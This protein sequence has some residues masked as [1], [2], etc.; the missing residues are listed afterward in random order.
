MYISS[1]H[2]CILYVCTCG[3]EWCTGIQMLIFASSSF[4]FQNVYIVTEC[5][6]MCVQLVNKQSVHSDGVCHYISGCKLCCTG[7]HMEPKDWSM[8][9][10]S[11]MYSCIH[12]SSYEPI[13]CINYEKHT[14]QVSCFFPLS[15]DL[16]SK[17]LD[18]RT[19]NKWCVC[20][21]L[22]DDLRNG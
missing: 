12:M 14:F 4:L 17:R 19:R 11:M 7:L 10:E 16:L 2:M 9:D 13:F 21:Y 5:A 20:R 22:L 15:L 6:G 18:F 3:S 8:K 1:S